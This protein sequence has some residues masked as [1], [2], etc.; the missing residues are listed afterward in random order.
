MKIKL[1]V[2]LLLTLSSRAFSQSLYYPSTAWQT[3]DP[4]SL[5]WCTSE[6]DS[7]YAFLQKG[8]SKAFVLLKDGKIVLEK[9]FGT[10]TQDSLWYWASAGKTL[11]AFAAGLAQQKG[12]LKLSDTSSKYLGK[13][14]SSLTAEQEAKITVWHHLTMTTGLDDATGNADC[15]D[16]NCL[17]YKAEPGTRW[18]YHNA[19]YTLL[20][21]IMQGAAGQNIN[22]FLNANVKPTTGMTGLFVKTGYNNVYFSNARSMARYGLLLLGEG[23]WNGSAVMTDT[24]YLRRMRNSSQTLNRSYG[25]LTWLN[26]KSS[27]MIPQSQIVFPGTLMPNAPSD[28]YAALG[29]NSQYINV[30]PSQGLVLVRMG[31]D[32]PEG[33]GLVPTAFNNNIWKYLNKIM[34]QNNTIVSENTSHY[35]IYPNPSQGILNISGE[36][37]DT[38]LIEIYNAKGQVVYAQY[39]AEQLDIRA[40]GSG[41]YSLRIVNHHGIY[42]EKIVLE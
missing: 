4:S 23:Q 3:T 20:D 16:K 37:K 33:G 29:K 35:R 30:V 10:F 14:W 5:G 15:T 27:F 8:D 41:I 31:N 12:F 1:L 22:A 7:L 11:T 9:Y 19:P 36:I 26:G 24:G 39:G 38:D 34:C 42:S 2:I 40:L 32:P 6:I 28:M 18:A 17:V 21:Q 25:Y 13:G